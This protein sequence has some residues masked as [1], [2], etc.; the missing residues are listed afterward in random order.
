[1]WA[2]YYYFAFASCFAV[3]YCV[4]ET[5][6]IRRGESRFACSAPPSIR[7]LLSRAASST[8][9]FACAG[10]KRNRDSRLALLGTVVCASFATVS[11][12]VQQA[13]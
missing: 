13:W 6:C 3:E 1:M 12:S 4:W 11:E 9:L 10:L 8:E 2:F 7:W 5:F